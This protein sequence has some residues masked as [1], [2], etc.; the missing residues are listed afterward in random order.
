MTRH[1]IEIDLHS[2]T[3]GSGGSRLCFPLPNDPDKCIKIC[4]PVQMLS[5]R[6]WRRIIRSWLANKISALNTNWHEYRFWQKHIQQA[7]IPGLRKF[8]P[9]CYGI[10]Q[11]SAG[12]GIVLECI[13]DANGAISPSLETWLPK[14]ART[15]RHAILTQLNTLTKLFID[16]K[17]PCYDWG[18]NNFLVQQTT[19]GLQL[20]LIDCEGDLGNREFIPIRTFIPRLRQAKIKKRIQRQLFVWLDQFET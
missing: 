11:T 10:I 5:K 4:R 17:L 12:S 15:D 1:P 8:F 18:P 20:K 7:P 9:R 16:Y 6:T 19:D 3:I 13:R 14:A 2:E